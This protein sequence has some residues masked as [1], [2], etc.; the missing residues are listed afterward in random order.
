MGLPVVGWFGRFGRIMN[1]QNK[2]VKAAAMNALQIQ[3]DAQTMLTAF[4][5]LKPSERIF[6]NAYIATDN[7]IT[8]IVDAFPNLAGSSVASVRAFDMLN[9]PLVQ[10]AIAQKVNALAARYDVSMESLIGEL[11]FIAKARFDDYFRI[12]PEGEP[13][14]DLSEASPEALSVISSVT[15][16]DVKDGRGPDAREIRK[17]RLTFHDKLAAIE[18]LIK[19]QG[20]Y[21]PVGVNV[22]V[23]G[24]LTNNAEAVKESM[25]AEQAAD[26]YQRSL[27]TE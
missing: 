4:D 19:I 20:G 11:A 8:A 1:N 15:V 25:T 24:G 22:N 14:V 23:S 12:T 27:E 10:A 2:P 3:R 6:V 5:Q 16:E 18:K 13:F 26:Y 17:V 9:R 7:P 21:A